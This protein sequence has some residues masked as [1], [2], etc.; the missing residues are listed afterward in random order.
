VCR[1]GCS[2]V[3]PGRVY[4]AGGYILLLSRRSNQVRSCGQLREVS[5]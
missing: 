1:Q 4:D 2:L 5:T 3:F